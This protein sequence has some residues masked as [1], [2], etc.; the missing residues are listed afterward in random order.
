VD[1]N[2][3]QQSLRFDFPHRTISIICIFIN[4][5]GFFQ[6]QAD[7][8]PKTMFSPKSF[9]NKVL[10]AS[11]PHALLSIIIAISTNPARIG[12]IPD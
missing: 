10:Q 4:N 9:I 6:I 7:S 1:G 2:F 5:I 12:I 3:S 8:L 11:S